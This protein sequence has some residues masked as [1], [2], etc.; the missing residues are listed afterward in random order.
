MNIAE[1]V[2]RLHDLYK[3]GALT[4]TEFEKAKAAVLAGAEPRRPSEQLPVVQEPH[5]TRVRQHIVYEEKPGFFYNLLKGGCIIWLA[6]IAL[7]AVFAI[8]SGFK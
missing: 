7:G 6:L 4:Q 5:E 1:E 3:Q 2:Q 8:L